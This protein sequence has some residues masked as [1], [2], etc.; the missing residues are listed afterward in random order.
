MRSEITFIGR[1]QGVGLRATA[2]NLAASHG[3][4]GWV[5]NEADGTVKL[6]A[7]A[8]EDVLNAYLAELRERL[9]EYIREVRATTS[10]A[11]G[12]YAGF[13]IR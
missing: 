3:V 8:E 5:R 1:V 12:R 6:V 10:N 2:H 4:T 13:E 11:T 7:E 9:G